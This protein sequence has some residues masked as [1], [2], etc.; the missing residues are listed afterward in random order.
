MRGGI[1]IMEKAKKID[2]DTVNHIALISRLGFTKKEL[3]IYTEQLDIILKYIDKLDELDTNDII[4][5]SH[6]IP[7]ENVFRDDKVRPSLDRDKVLE[8]A[9]K[10]EKGYFKVPK[11]VE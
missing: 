5:T 2:Q 11:I 7:T 4:P 10:V 9:P 8:M 3:A 6:V 1:K